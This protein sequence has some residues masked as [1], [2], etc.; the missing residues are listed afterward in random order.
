MKTQN[1]I[2]DALRELWDSSKSH[3]NISVESGL[4]RLHEKMGI[5][6]ADRPRFRF[7]T[8]LGYSIAAIL[9]IVCFSL[10]VELYKSRHLQDNLS[11]AVFTV[12]AGSDGPSSMTL[13]DGT[14][15]MLNV[16]SSISYNADFGQVDRRVTLVGEG[17]FDVVKD[18]SRKFTVNTQNMEI[19]VHGTKFNVYA[20][21]ERKLDEISLL[22]G[23]VSVIAGGNELK[24]VPGEKVV[25]DKSAESTYLSKTDNAKEMSWL[26]QELSFNH[27]SLADVFDVLER[28]FGITIVTDCAIDINDRYTGSFTDRRIGDI[29]DILRMHYHF[30]YTISDNIIRL[31][32]NNKK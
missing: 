26:G 32:S 7:R 8:A 2:N 28:R 17:F 31:T 27:K 30:D 11:A 21:P 9:T 5:S 22:E 15:V 25:Y 19:S 10:S 12:S 18:A 16:R 29:M 3:K 23:S 6:R 1:Q 24:M 20:Y 4:E 14:L 13:P